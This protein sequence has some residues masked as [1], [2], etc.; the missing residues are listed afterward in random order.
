MIDTCCYLVLWVTAV[1]AAN[2]YFYAGNGCI[3][4]T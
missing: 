1:L 2:R 4:I 3:H